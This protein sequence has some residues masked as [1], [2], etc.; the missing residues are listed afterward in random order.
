V[1]GVGWGGVGWGGVGWGGVGSVP[2]GPEPVQPP[3]PSAA[4]SCSNQR[5]RSCSNPCAPLTPP[6]SSPGE[7][8]YLDLVPWQALA[9]ANNSFL[10]TERRRHYARYLG[11]LTFFEVNGPSGVCAR[12]PVK[13]PVKPTADCARAR[14]R[15][16]LSPRIG[17]GPPPPAPATPP[18]LRSP[19]P[20]SPPPAVYR[21]YLAAAHRCGLSERACGYWELH[22]REDERHGR[23]MLEKVAL[24]LA[25]M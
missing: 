5:A 8:A 15:C 17:R 1:R 12:A 20:A 21:A 23:Q 11:A 19:A 2:L 3:S 6:P 18:R 24:P 22:I 7:E 13:R 10:L 25:E 9:N 16:C 4:R 14:G